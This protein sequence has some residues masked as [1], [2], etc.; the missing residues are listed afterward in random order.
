MAR[1][2][3]VPLKSEPRQFAT[4]KG[5][6]FEQLVR[7]LLRRHG[8]T[9]VET[10]RVNYAGMEIDIEGTHTI[11]GHPF[12]AEC[13]AH[14]TPLAAPSLH[15]FVGK[16]FPRWQEEKRLHGVF[17]ALPGINSHARGYWNRT[18]GRSSEAT[19]ALLEEEQVISGLVQGGLVPPPETTASCR[20]APDDTTLGDC[21]LAATE[22]GYFWLQLLLRRG[23]T[24]PSLAFVIDS[25][26][27]PLPDGEVLRALTE[28]VPELQG[29]TVLEAAA[30]V[31]ASATVPDLET[32]DEVASVKASSSWFEYHFP[33]APEYFV[34]REQAIE[35]I[36]TLVDDVQARRTS[37]RGVLVQANSGWG[38][39]SLILKTTQALRSRNCLVIPIDCRAASTPYFPL[40]AVDYALSQATHAGFLTLHRD[41]LRIGGMSSLRAVLT[42]VNEH[43]CQS[44]KL[45]CIA[46]DQFEG[47]FAAPS[48]LENLA[49]LASMVTD[50][51]GP[52]L[53]C[54]AWKTDL[55]GLT[56]E[57]PFKIR[58]E[59]SNSCKTVT[60]HPFGE[61]E[62]A[63]LLR[64]LQTELRARPRGD[65]A[66]LL[67]ESSQGYPW[68]LKK[69]CAHVLAQRQ[70]G[71][72]QIELA[73][74][75]LRIKELFDQDLAG[76]SP[77][78]E[79]ALHHI[80]RAAPLPFADVIE[81]V[82]A[83]VLYSLID[84]RLLVRVATKCDVYWD[85]FKDY[86][87]TGAVPVEES[88]IL[89]ASIGPVLSALEAIRTAGQEGSP[90][91]PQA[92]QVKS[93]GTLYNILRDLQHLGLVEVRDATVSL[94]FNASP[95]QPI[96]MSLAAP[97]Q[98]KMRRHRIVRRFSAILEDSDFLPLSRA[99]QIMKQMC[100]Y[101]TAHDKTWS[102]YA[103]VL[104]SWLQIARVAAVDRHQQTL[105]RFDPETDLRMA[106]AVWSGR[107][108]RG[109]PL[110]PPVRYHRLEAAMLDLS[111]AIAAESQAWL[112]TRL[113][114]AAW[115]Q[116]FPV[117]VQLGLTE[118]VG[119]NMVRITD[120][121]AAFVSMPEQR[122]R[123]FH[124]Q[125][126]DLIPA[127]AHFIAIIRDPTTHNWGTPQ[128]GR[129]VA[130]RLGVSWTDNTADW[131][132]KIFV[133]WAK[134]AGQMPSGRR[135][136]R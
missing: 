69:L 106:R 27:H 81:T 39:S 115:W 32:A 128:L 91:T 104:A 62:T 67:R 119:E 23:Q 130:R 131:A 22:V 82:P 8:Y 83:D 105:R 48:I 111:D 24:T 129:E 97:L 125:A 66:F 46:F 132:A 54:F 37:H 36:Q 1:L 6:L 108:S 65:L 74:Q 75:M 3:I 25:D 35:A 47:V 61:S 9:I 136:P 18:A 44:G 30:P 56:Q 127:Y 102:T 45:I 84:R 124:A 59:L 76:L 135:R 134:A 50:L 110:I 13:K 87:N 7:D 4:D 55:V 94:A 120:A 43:L 100:P 64:A 122:P 72:T 33:A 12:I 42:R 41:S 117:A 29:I 71:I 10:P 116:A 28:H 34:G 101:I 58:D 123:I 38:K 93:Q 114:V 17:V 126:L 20:L 92:F 51:A 14:E 21:L 90:L 77:K 79:E 2:R 118:V 109:G 103:R 26:G 107:R 96:E 121:G 19:L 113:D 11:F 31:P 68:L 5:K 15:A 49:R 99:A 53:L 95:D 133:N 86:L 98:D 112:P 40:R 57:F 78:E 60:L 89:R 85:I 63:A 80:A 16:W 70:A 73:T 88:Y 52:I